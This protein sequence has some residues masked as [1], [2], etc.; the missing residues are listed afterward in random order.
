M[1]IG[2]IGRREDV[3]QCNQQAGS[4]ADFC[5]NRP[6]SHYQFYILFAGNI[7]ST[8]QLIF[9]LANNYCVFREPNGERASPVPLTLQHCP[10][11]IRS[12]APRR[13]TDG[14]DGGCMRL[15]ELAKLF[16]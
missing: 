7:S 4:S 9:F 1:V 16:R 3:T 11:G 5:W 6:N 15:V 8:F 2:Q 13:K 12:A 10:L 14:Q